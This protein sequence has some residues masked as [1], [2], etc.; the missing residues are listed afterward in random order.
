MVLA[1][2]RTGVLPNRIK[3]DTMKTHTALLCLAIILISPMRPALAASSTHC[4]PLMTEQEC[5][6]YKATLAQ[7]T[8]GP[9][10]EHYLAE[11]LATM[12][13]REAACSCNQKTQAGMTSRMRKQ[14]LLRF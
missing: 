13:E 4:H 10:L 2:Y 9:A 3:E 11:H 12:Q 1:E 14:A 7:L 6:Q 8:P 5:G